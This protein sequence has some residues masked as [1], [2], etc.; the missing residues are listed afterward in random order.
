[1]AEVRIAPPPGKR[2]DHQGIRVTLQGRIIVNNDKN[3]IM[4]VV[5]E[6]I[7][8]CR[9]LKLRAVGSELRLV[10]DVTIFITVQTMNYLHSGLHR[11]AL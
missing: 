5:R 9:E 3:D 2:L 6:V 1:M 8:R 11:V 10:R 4:N 7:D